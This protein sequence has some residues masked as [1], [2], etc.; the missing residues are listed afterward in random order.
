[1]K[2]TF[3]LK[4]TQNL[5]LLLAKGRK[6]IVNQNYSMKRLLI[7][8]LG[9]VETSSFRKKSRQVPEH[10]QYNTTTSTIPS[11]PSVRVH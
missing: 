9:F 1:M 5:E 4:G 10:K 8:S 7:W 11:S 6:I 2:L 3:K